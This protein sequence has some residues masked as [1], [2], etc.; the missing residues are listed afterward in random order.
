MANP[1]T[2]QN[3]ELSL[4]KSSTAEQSLLQSLV[5]PVDTFFACAGAGVC[6]C[7]DMQNKRLTLQVRGEQ[8]KHIG[9]KD[10]TPYCLLFYTFKA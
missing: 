1:Q 10:S 7:V 5:G 2:F 3:E 4:G 9:P 6:A 8:H